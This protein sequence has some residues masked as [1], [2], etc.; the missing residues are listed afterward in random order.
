MHGRITLESSLGNGT[1]AT[2]WI[3]FNKPQ[4]HDGAIVDIGSLPDRLQ[5][6]MSVSCNSS[7]YEQALGTPPEQSPLGRKFKRGSVSM[8]P[9]TPIELE[10]HPSERS[11]VNILLVEDK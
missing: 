4:Y 9:T 5:S 10:L 11:K 7:E 6:E 8:T 3:P 1:T 2:F